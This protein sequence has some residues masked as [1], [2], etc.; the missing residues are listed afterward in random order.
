MGAAGGP[1]PPP[2]PYSTQHHA[3]RAP[4]YGCGRA[5]TRRF[6]LAGAW[7]Q[8]ADRRRHHS[9]LTAHSITQRAP[10][11]LAAAACARAAL[12]RQAHGRS[13]RTAAAPTAT[14]QH[15]ASRSARPSL[16][17]RPRAHAQ[18]SFR[19]RMGAAG[20][21]PPPTQPY[22]T[23]HHAARAPAFGCGR[24][25]T[26]KFLLAGAWA[27]RADRR[28]HSNL[29]AHSIMQHAPQHL[30][31]AASARAGWFRQANGRSR[32]PA[33]ATASLQHTA[34]RSTHPSIWL[35]PRAHAQVCLGR[36]MGA[37]GGPPPPQHPYSTQHHAARA[38]ASGWGRARTR[39]FV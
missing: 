22:S 17:L 11:L 6:L 18:V 35:R 10:Q 36:R 14:L 23:Q 31:A 39:S 3:A 15:T 9:N 38:T 21:P 30:A 7:A 32:R 4:A 25:R 19:R 33:A 29:T 26:R 8:Q 27:Q 34:S 16:W 13:G 24:A 12:L 1:P 37:A 2:Q 5:R 20:G 28:R